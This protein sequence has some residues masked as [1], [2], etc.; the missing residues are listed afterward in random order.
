MRA[1]I[2]DGGIGEIRSV[3]ADLGFVNDRDLPRLVEPSAGGGVL[4]DC[5]VYLVAFAQWLLGTP[6]SVAV[7]GLIG[8]TGVDIEA[9]MLLGFAD[10]AH[11]ILSCSFTSDSPGTVTIVGTAGHIVIEPRFHHTPGIRVSRRGAG[12]LRLDNQLIGSGLAH[13]FIHVAEC[14][15][16]SRSESPIMPL[17]DTLAVMAVLDDAVEQVGS[18]H[19]DEGFTPTN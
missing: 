19:R 6:T 7:H 13:E 5:G 11:A 1:L 17:D 12:T 10:G 2:A 4:L 8:P 14:L 9:G 16:A 3:H 15:R 18:P